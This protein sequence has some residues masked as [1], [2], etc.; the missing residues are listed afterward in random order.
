[1]ARP[2]KLDFDRLVGGAATLKALLARDSGDKLVLDA[3]DWWQGTPEGTLSKGE[4][5]AEVFNA[6][7]YDAI[8]VGNHEFDA[9]V[10]S[11]KSLIGKMA[12]PVL[13]A[14]IDGPDG[15]HVSWTNQRVVKEV[16]GV[17]FGIFGLLTVHMTKLAFPKSIAGLTFRREADEA[18]DQVD[19]AQKEGA[20]VI[21]AVTHV[22]FEAPDKSGFRGRPDDRAR[23]RGDRPDRRAAT[24]TRPWRVRGATPAR[25]A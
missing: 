22:G 14:N 18:R 16:G 5:V 3:G 11:L 10:D 7:G 6:I 20:D 1:M 25:H 21:I 13:A 9:G 4:A 15:K 19:G 2:D 24:R 17:K 8:E 23:G 12:M